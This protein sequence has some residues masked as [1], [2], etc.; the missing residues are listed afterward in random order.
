MRCM[1]SSRCNW[2]H[3]VY[4]TADIPGNTCSSQI[5]KSGWWFLMTTYLAGGK[6]TAH[7]TGNAWP[8][9][10]S[11]GH[12]PH[13]IMLLESGVVTTGGLFIKPTVKLFKRE[14]VNIRKCVN[15]WTIY[16]SSQPEH[17]CR[18]NKTRG[19]T[20][21]GDS[22]DQLSWVCKH[23]ILNDEMCLIDKASRNPSHQKRNIN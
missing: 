23:D 13:V 20:I 4:R 3:D 16:L 1:H 18:V 21:S 19:I 11:P 8:G 2:S 6:P 9:G 7:L 17:S 10:A 12:W 5:V 15:I 22:T 14:A